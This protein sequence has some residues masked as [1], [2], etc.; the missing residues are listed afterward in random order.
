M[1]VT[2]SRAAA[3]FLPLLL[4]STVAACGED[5]RQAG[6]GE[7]G[8]LV[9]E[10]SV[11]GGAVFHEG[12]LTVLRIVEGDGGRVVDHLQSV[13]RVDVAVLD[14]RLA[15]GTYRLT[16]VERPCE[17]MCPRLDPPFD[18]TRC[19]IAV[20]VR[21]GRTTR[22][23]ITLRSTPVGPRSDCAASLG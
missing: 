21:A 18:A 8:R 13:A 2:A 23:A 19:E 1:V 3:R 17:A 11:P 14:R 10:K 20:D 6:S 9:V 5:Q 7:P 16:A 12:S 4:A 22:V 15:A